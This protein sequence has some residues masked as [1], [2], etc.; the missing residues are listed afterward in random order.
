MFNEPRARSH[1]K[2]IGS[3]V[4]PTETERI[5][6]DDHLQAAVNCQRFLQQVRAR[7][8]QSIAQR[9]SSHEHRQHDRLSVDRAPQHEREVF[10]PNDLI[11]QR[12]RAGTEE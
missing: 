11:D 10:G 4:N 6:A 8:D 2:P 3:L 1:K 7:T 12:C 5:Q 9:Q